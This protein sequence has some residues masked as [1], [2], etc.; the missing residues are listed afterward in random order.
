[1]FTVTFVNCKYHF[2]SDFHIAVN[3]FVIKFIIL[4]F[5]SSLSTVDGSRLIYFG[6][7][8]VVGQIKACFISYGQRAN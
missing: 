3:F 4:I 5:V 7:F 8:F 2:R 6:L 1:M